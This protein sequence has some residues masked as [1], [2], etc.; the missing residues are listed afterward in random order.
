LG[1]V[2]Q[3]CFTFLVF[4]QKGALLTAMLFSCFLGVER[5]L[6][7]DRPQ[8]NP[9]AE[10]RQDIVSFNPAYCAEMGK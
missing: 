4:A 2:G 8:D 10:V 1:S 7:R 5:D 6:S 9:I 3:W